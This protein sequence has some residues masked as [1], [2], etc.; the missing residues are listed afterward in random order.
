MINKIITANQDK[1]INFYLRILIKLGLALILFLPLVTNSDFYF[2]FIV[3]RNLLFRFIL[4]VILALYTYLFL[5]DKQFRP[6]FNK[7]F[8]IFCAFIFSLT[9]SSLLGGN[10]PFSFWSNYE[11]MDGLSNWYFLI[12]YVV[13]MLGTLRNRQDWKQFF[14][15]SIVAAWLISWYGL[16]QKLGWDQNLNFIMASTGGSR[17]ASTLGNAAYVGSYMFMHII[18]SLYL[19]I[20]TIMK[21]QLISFKTFWYVLSLMLFTAVLIL[22]QTRGAFLGLALFLFLLVIF[23][24]WFNRN[25]I[26][27]WYYVVAALL[28]SGV[29]FTGLLFQQKES[30]WVNNVLLF[31][32]ITD[33]SLSDTTVES[34]LSIWQNSFKG[35]LDKPVLGWGD[36][37]FQYVFNKY[38]PVEI[39]HS[40]NSEVW[41]DRPHNI[42]I[43]HLIHGGSIGLGLYLGMFA[44]LIYALIKKYKKDKQWFFSFF[45]IAFLVSFLL[46]DMFIFDSI[47]TNVT[48]YLMLAFLFKIGVS[49]GYKHINLPIKK[50]DYYR[51]GGVVILGVILTVFMVWRPMQGNLLLMSSLQKVSQLRP[52]NNSVMIE[53]SNS[54]FFREAIDDWKRSRD[55]SFLGDKEKGEVL[56]RIFQGTTRATYLKPENQEEIF[57]LTQEYLE[58]ISDRYPKDVRQNLFLSY[59]YNVL[60]GTNLNFSIKNVE[61]L[62]GLKDWATQRPDV[63]TQLSHAYLMVGDFDAGLETA[64]QAQEL[65]PET[66]FVYWN[67]LNAYVVTG[68]IGN[69]QNTLEKIII[70]NLRDNG[71]PFELPE[72][73]QLQVLMSQ[74]EK[75]NQP[76]IKQ[77]IEAYL[78]QE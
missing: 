2:P 5:K 76:E 11:R 42:L 22:T 25:K 41:F 33:V 4:I 10:F 74:A 69:I 68:D 21:K 73:Q 66:K 67:L 58:T 61:L 18:L 59:F 63:Y 23:Y 38:F 12:V 78:L 50:K 3:P 60:S 43:Q 46:H 31:Q 16:A 45:W 51:A 28:I 35:Y 47:N 14:N 24:L 54:G 9:V 1:D 75:N 19:L 15:I 34:R 40:I 37:N 70:I 20:I 52:T 13:I 39:Y 72:M 17:I 77:A 8:I 44:Y 71:R 6:K 56:L 27:A 29:L 64:L 36:E 62:E 30:A 65:V 48:L 57:E 7:A 26:N 32:K 49:D 53:Q 55:I